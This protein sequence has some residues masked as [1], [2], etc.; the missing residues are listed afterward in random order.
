MIEHLGLTT[1]IITDIDSAAAAGHHAAQQPLRGQNQITRNSTIKT[2]VPEKEALEEVLN[3]ASANKIKRAD[4]DPFF[5]VRVAYQTPIQL[6]FNAPGTLVEALSNT[7]EDALVFENI[8]LFR[9]LEGEGMIKQFKEAIIAAAN[10]AALGQA[11]FDI[12]KN[13]QQSTICAGF[14]LLQEPKTLKVPSYIAEGLGWLQEV[15]N[16]KQKEIAATIATPQLHPSLP[17]VQEEPRDNGSDS[18]R[19]QSR[20]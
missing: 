4:N 19:R 5:F 6:R 7:F 17:Q 16:E 3:T 2:W 8:P 1:L 20:G 15:L 18:S 14:A 12:F 9:A 13:R 10:V 11:M